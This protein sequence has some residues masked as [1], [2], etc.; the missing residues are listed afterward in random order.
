MILPCHCQDPAT[1]VPQSSTDQ[2]DSCQVLVCTEA[3]RESRTKCSSQHSQH[4]S[5]LWSS[6]WRT[7]WTDH[8]P[9]TCRRM[10][11]NIS[12]EMVQI[13]QNLPPAPR[14]TR[15]MLNPSHKELY[16]TH[17][18]DQHQSDLESAWWTHVL[19]QT[20]HK[21][22]LPTPSIWTIWLVNRYF[23]LIEQ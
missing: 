5:C 20:L 12:W 13:Q 17:H 21:H 7:V 1:S 9:E 14:D 3:S 6:Q 10:F 18:Q 2:P 19:D 11:G 4:Q 8:C 16:R 23:V 15:E 22:T